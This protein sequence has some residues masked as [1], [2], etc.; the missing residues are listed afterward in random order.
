MEKG[1]TKISRT[2]KG[3][4]GKDIVLNFGRKIFRKVFQKK[5]DDPVIQV[6]PVMHN[7]EQIKFMMV[8]QSAVGS[9]FA[10]IKK[11]PPSEDYLLGVADCFN[12]LLKE[13]VVDRARMY[14]IM[15]EIKDG[16]R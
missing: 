3:R 5:Q 4:E 15:R 10:K 8:I 7:S 1:K 13:L 16:K 6:K 12:I 2:S 11:R 14:K 9:N